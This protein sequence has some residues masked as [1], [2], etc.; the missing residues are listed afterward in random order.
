[1]KT[2]E[3][4]GEL[5]AALANVQSKIVDAKKD[6]K[7]YGY[8]YA[9]LAQVLQI[10]RPLLSSN[11]LALIQTTNNAEGG[12]AVTTR[13]AHTSGQWV[14]D[15]FAVPFEKAKGLSAEQ[16]AGSTITYLR[17]YG[18][19]AI[20]GLTQDDNDGHKVDPVPV[21]LKTKDYTEEAARL[22]ACENITELAKVW[23]KLP[24]D[25][26]AALGDLK[27]ELKKRVG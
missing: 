8:N 13:L 22:E 15:T 23:H 16:S 7:G 10:L 20:V 2:S 6:K 12:I 14:E 5:A 27:N 4:I 19:A 24:G 1:M 9:D 17:R 21:E 26:K 11:N 18:A 3:K 25:A